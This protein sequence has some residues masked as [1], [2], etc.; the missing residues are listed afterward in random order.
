[1]AT[2]KEIY[3]ELDALI[4]ELEQYVENEDNGTKASDIQK[5]V[6]DRLE[7]AVNEL[8]TIIDDDNAGL[9]EEYGEDEFL[10]DSEDS[11]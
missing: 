10:E 5:N 8:D 4:E 3:A 1:M 2:L 7:Y 6:L 9:Y 11:W